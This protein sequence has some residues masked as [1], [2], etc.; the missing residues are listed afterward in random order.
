MSSL[1][2]LLPP[3]LPPARP[4]PRRP[5]L[6]LFVPA[7][8]LAAGTGLERLNAAPGDAL[9]HW[10]C[11]SSAAGLCIGAL[12]GLLF[13]RKL[14]WAAYGVAAP[15][16]VPGLAAGSV[17]LAQP[18]RDLYADGEEAFCRARG[19]ALC[20]A[21][22]FTARCAQARED[23]ARATSLLGDPRWSSCAAQGCVRR[24]LYPGPFRPEQSEAP[25]L[26]CFV[27]S[28]PQG[29]GLRHWVTATELP[30]D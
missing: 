25:A 19:R 2:E 28:D 10:L 12:S 20:T 23:P 17:R 11:W 14:W 30:T 3:P 4:F 13:G 27:L 22:D 24:W 6:A 16:L 18:V 21:A 29:R 7:A 9:L 26:A 8:A 1:E 5:L 15:W